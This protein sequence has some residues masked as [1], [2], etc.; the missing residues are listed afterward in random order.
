MATGLRRRGA[1]R[2]GDSYFDV[3]GSGRASSTVRSSPMWY[4]DVRRVAE[5]MPP[6]TRPSI[7]SRGSRRSSHSGASLR[8]GAVPVEGD[9]LVPKKP[10]S[11]SE[12]ERVH[13]R[14]QRILGWFGVGTTGSHSRP[15]VAGCRRDRLAGLRCG[16]ARKVVYF[17]SNKRGWRRLRQRSASRAAG[18]FRPDFPGWSPAGAGSRRWTLAI[19]C[20]ARDL[21][22]FGVRSTLTAHQ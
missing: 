9:L 19:R 4:A 16:D 10:R 13:T 18:H 15:S 8:S 14:V 3:A 12:I 21:E 22:L 20:E 17:A 11:V 5:C 2:S 1:W 6:Q 7:A